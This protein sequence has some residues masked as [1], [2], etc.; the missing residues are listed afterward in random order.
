MATVLKRLSNSAKKY[1]SLIQRKSVTIKATLIAMRKSPRRVGSQTR[2]PK[3]S[4]NRLGRAITAERNELNPIIKA[5]PAR[6]QG[7][8]AKRPDPSTRRHS[9]APKPAGANRTQSTALKTCQTMSSITLRPR[10]NRTKGQK[11]WFFAEEG[12]L[13]NKL[14][15]V[16]CVTILKHIS[17]TNSRSSRNSR[18]I[19]CDKNRT[20]GASAP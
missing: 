5:D 13:L 17:Y 19:L 15:Y 4:S 14:A 6:E 11:P 8:S 2:N 16:V 7:M 20:P 18:G 9:T 1:H 3:G 12:N 10:G